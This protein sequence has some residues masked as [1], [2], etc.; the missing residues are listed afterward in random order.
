M[1]AFRLAFLA[2]IVLSQPAAL[3][4]TIEEGKV[5]DSR[6]ISLTIYNQDFGVVKDVRTINLA[7]GMNYLRMD[8]VAAQIDPT[9]DTLMTGFPYVMPLI[10]QRAAA[11]AAATA[12]EASEGE[13]PGLPPQAARPS[14]ATATVATTHPR[15]PP[16]GVRASPACNDN[17]AFTRL[18]P[19]RGSARSWR[20]TPIDTQRR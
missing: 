17:F 2:A 10:S 16:E 7:D 14:R 5:S 19:T 11:A 15:L 6:D 8:D 3:A 9:M 20:S 13:A 12:G 4:G 18:R 1:L